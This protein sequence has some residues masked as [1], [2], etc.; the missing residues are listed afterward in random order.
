[1]LFTDKQWQKRNLLGGGNK[2]PWE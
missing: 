2:I 1:M